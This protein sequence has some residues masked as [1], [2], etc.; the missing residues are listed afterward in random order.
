MNIIHVF[1]WCNAFVDVMICCPIE[2]QAAQ[3]QPHVRQGTRILHKIM[4][5]WS[6]F[7]MVSLKGLSCLCLEQTLF[8]NPL[9]ISEVYHIIGIKFYSC[10]LYLLDS[11]P[12]RLTLEISFSQE[13]TIAISTTHVTRTTEY[14]IQ[15]TT[16]RCVFRWVNIRY[17]NATMS[18][19][20]CATV[21]SIIIIIVIMIK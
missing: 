18:T 12:Q 20:R 1:C 4:T 6:G 13:I 9:T 17:N 15:K 8:G 7:F 3:T 10:R 5:I 11:Y 19:A 21:L 14:L 2:E 16:T